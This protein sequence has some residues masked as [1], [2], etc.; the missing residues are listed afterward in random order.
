MSL[1]TDHIE[2]LI[3]GDIASPDQNQGDNKPDDSNRPADNQ[4]QGHPSD[5]QQRDQQ[6]Q[7]QQTQDQQKDQ[8]SKDQQK[9]VP[10]KVPVGE[11]QEERRRRQKLEQ[12]VRELEGK[13]GEFSGLSDELKEWRESQQRARDQ[14]D[15][16]QAPPE[17]IPDWNTDELGYLQA[18]EKEIK[19]DLE[20][21][22]E[23]LERL[24]LERRMEAIQRE[25]ISRA[26][27]A[28]QEFMQ[29][30]ADYRDARKYVRESVLAELQFRGYDQQTAVEAL[31]RSELEFCEGALRN[32][33]NPAEQLY[34]IAKIRGYRPAGQGADQ[35]QQQG[36]SS[37]SSTDTDAQLADLQRRQEANQ[38]GGASGN[39]RQLD[40]LNELPDD[41]FERARMER[42]AYMNKSR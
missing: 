26:A 29:Q 42:Y 22:K 4:D 31:K 18:K 34:E 35:N 20:T 9:Q 12:Q 16:Q 37:G 2:N 38:G 3:A 28:E 25:I 21:Q 41:E 10:D 1:P 14:A 39:S 30:Q 8:Q 32:K 15:Q 33:K 5:Q 7:D 40:K 24:E 36:Q 19:T 13:I 6:T 27:M 23:R 11:L 17:Q